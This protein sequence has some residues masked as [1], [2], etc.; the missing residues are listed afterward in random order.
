V[1]RLIIFALILLFQGTAVLLTAAASRLALKLG[2][3]P[4]WYLALPGAI[5]AAFLVI[6]GESNSFLFEVV[7]PNDDG[8]WGHLT[9]TEADVGWLFL[10]SMAIALIPAWLAVRHARKK[11]SDRTQRRKSL[12]VIA[13]AMAALALLLLHY[14]DDRL[15]INI[16][17]WHDPESTGDVLR[18]SA[19]L[20]GAFILFTSLVVR[21]CHKK[22]SSRRHAFIGVLFFT[23]SSLGLA[24][25]LFHFRQIDFYRCQTCLAEREVVQW[26]FGLWTRA[27]VPTS[28]RQEFAGKTHF[29][30]DFFPAD[31]AHV[32]KLADTAPYH[33]FGTMRAGFAGGD[34]QRPNLLFTLYEWQPEARSYIDARIQKGSLTRSRAIELISNHQE[35]GDPAFLQQ[36]ADAVSEDYLWNHQPRK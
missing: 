12:L 14:R 4:G 7:H 32:W 29:C 26:R 15:Q 36:E 2:R 34:A 10:G 1:K 16:A 8:H 17:N 27:S 6:L 33:F 11:F 13:G 18:S 24:L 5:A 3:K 28:P 23:G 19:W 25:L 22:F 20:M 30:I 35:K 31:H 9:E 21:Q